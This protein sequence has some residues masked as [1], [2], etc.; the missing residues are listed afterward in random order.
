MR[1]LAFV[2][3]NAEYTYDIQRVW[4]PN[5]TVLIESPMRLGNRICREMFQYFRFYY[6]SGL[7]TPPTRKDIALLGLIGSLVGALCKRDIFDLW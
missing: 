4:F 2:Q 5:R 7:Q 6:K 3:I 1:F